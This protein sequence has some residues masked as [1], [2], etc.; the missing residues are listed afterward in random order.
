MTEG[1]PRWRVR[2]LAAL[3]LATTLGATAQGQGQAP[4]A[5][6]PFLKLV[7][8]WPDAKTM[9]QRKVEA[10]AL[11][12]FAEKIGERSAIVAANSRRGGSAGHPA[13]CCRIHPGRF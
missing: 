5:K 4:P 10:E 13:S 6:N 12:L 11:R 8:P 1:W 9:R 3:A 7:E 2:L